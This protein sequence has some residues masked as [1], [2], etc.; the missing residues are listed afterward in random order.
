MLRFF[1]PRVLNFFLLWIKDLLDVL[2]T[3]LTLLMIL[4]STVNVI[5]LLIG[6]S[7][8][9]WLLN[10]NL[11]LGIHLIWD[12]LWFI[13]F[14]TWKTRF[15]MSLKLLCCYGCKNGWACSWYKPSFKMA[16]LSFFFEPDWSLKR[17]SEKNCFLKSETWCVQWNFL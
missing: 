17:L 5:R 9:S 3:L 1:K 7:S 4:F 16:E 10:L 6:G 14:D 8:L 2:C 13:E 12:R 11:T 15:I